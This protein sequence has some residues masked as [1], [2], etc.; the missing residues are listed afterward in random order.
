[1]YTAMPRNNRGSVGVEVDYGKLRLRLPRSLATG[2]SRYITT[3][4]P[5]TPENRKLVQARAWEIERDIAAGTLDP[6]LER[7]RFRPITQA[8]LTIVE[9]IKPRPLPTLT[10]LWSAYAEHRKPQVA[11]TTYLNHYQGHYTRLIAK[12]PTARLEDAVAIRLWLLDNLTTDGAK[13]ALTQF[14][15]AC[16]HAVRSG[17]LKDNPFEGMA[18]EIRKPPRDSQAIDPFTQPEMITVLNAFKDSDRYRRYYPLIRFLF[19]TGCRP[20]E[21]V[22]LCW[23][24]VSQDYK[25][26]TFAETYS[27]RHRLRKGTKTGKARKF[28]CNPVLQELLASLARFDPD[29]SVFLSPTGL[30]VNIEHLSLSIWHGYRKHPGI[31]G[32]LAREGRIDHYR[33]L[34]NTRHTFATLALEGGLTVPQVARL[35]GNSPEIVLRHYA[36][37]VLGF[38]V[39]V[40]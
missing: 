7:Y 19:L 40:T 13:R 27:S 36:G 14:S 25:T 21:A 17:T 32:P 16:D 29:Q 39:P 34:Y 2:S 8:T 37:N 11:P 26:I 10:E 12:L 1:M 4:L 24:H 20:G 28:P 9:A 6:T 22:G 30:P 38:E 15:A 31:V 23:R 18:V 5:D 33:P 3:G 35:L